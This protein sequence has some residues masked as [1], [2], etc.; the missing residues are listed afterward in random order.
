MQLVVNDKQI[1]NNEDIAIFEKIIDTIKSSF[2]EVVSYSTKKGLLSKEKEI[3]IC[4]CGDKN[5]N[6]KKY[7]NSCERDKY[8]FVRNKINPPKAIKVLEEKIEILKENLV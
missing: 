5:N 2:Q 4:Q 6:E 8:G 1:Y 7:C 3:W